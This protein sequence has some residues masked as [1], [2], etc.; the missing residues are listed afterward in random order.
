MSCLHALPSFL[1]YWCVLFSI[2]SYR[3]VVSIR[4]WIWI[5]PF[6]VGDGAESITDPDKEADEPSQT[7]VYAF[8]AKKLSSGN[9]RGSS[10]PLAK[11]RRKSSPIANRWG[12]LHRLGAPS[13]KGRC[14]Q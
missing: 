1:V 12:P 4:I 13:D 8:V 3:F 11:G 7:T 5:G 9:N 10:K 6:L 2:F 14:F